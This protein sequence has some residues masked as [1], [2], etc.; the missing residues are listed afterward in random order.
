MTLTVD[1]FNALP[2]DAS[3]EL[4]RSCCGSSRWV[5][6]MIGRRPFGS[7]DAL[8]VAADQSWASTDAGDWHE[9]FA[10]HPRIGEGQSVAAQDARASS[11]SRAEQGAIGAAS[12]GTQAEIAD[13]NQE[14]ER[15]FGHIYIACA[16]G[17]TPSELLTV[18][19][20]RLANDAD[21]ELLTAAEE[22]RQ[23]MHLRL[24]KLF[25]GHA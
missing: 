20:R 21:I 18:A 1:D 5:D 24:R 13:M 7:L 9:A 14:Y 3:A 23:I 6:E 16:S 10:H 12:E 19:R 22:Q 2:A 25:G 11:W 4:L 17:R 15:R 8:L